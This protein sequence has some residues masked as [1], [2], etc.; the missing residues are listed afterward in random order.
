MTILGLRKWRGGLF[1]GRRGAG[2][3]GVQ[4]ESTAVRFSQYL[5]LY[6]VG[7]TSFEPE[8]KF[9]TSLSIR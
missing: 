1:E 4:A 5:R 2:D 9:E 6:L 8:T 7:I 3:P